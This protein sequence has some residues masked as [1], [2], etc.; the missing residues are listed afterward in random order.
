MRKACILALSVFCAIPVQADESPMRRFGIAWETVMTQAPTR[1]ST[2]LNLPTVMPWEAETRPVIVVTS[3]ECGS[4]ADRKGIR[5]GDILMRFDTY[6]PGGYP[7][8]LFIE[9]A[10]KDSP[11]ITLMVFERYGNIDL[12]FYDLKPGLG[13]G[14]FSCGF[15]RG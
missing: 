12:Y 7:A 10:V 15:D 8:R 3:V 13:N 1:G 11:S 14:D 9:E 4:D 2:Y 5:A 6:L